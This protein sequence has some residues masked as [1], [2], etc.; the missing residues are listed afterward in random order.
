[1]KGKISAIL[2]LMLLITTVFPI[3]QSINTDNNGKNLI[4]FDNK[5]SYLENSV[6][7]EPCR[8]CISEELFSI[9]DD[10]Y[11]YPVMPESDLKYD[12]AFQSPRPS[13][14][15][16]LPDEFSWKDYLGEELIRLLQLY[17]EALWIRRAGSFLGLTHERPQEH[18]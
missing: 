18:R 17:N 3:S 6:E 15:D 5:L 2:I 7:E 11:Q 10:N 9:I 1:M 4:N 13:I 12:E 8:S 16:D 14:I